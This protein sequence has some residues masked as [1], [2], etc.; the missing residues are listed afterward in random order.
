MSEAGRKYYHLYEDRYKK[1]YAQG[2][3]YWSDFP[4]EVKE[5]IEGLE[6]LFGM[7]EAQTVERAGL[8][9][10]LDEEAGQPR[11]VPAEGRRFRVLEPGCGEGHLAVQCLARGFDYVGIDLAPTAL[12]KARVR[13]EAMAGSLD[14]RETRGAILSGLTTRSQFG[15]A[16]LLCRDVTALSFLEPVS[17]DLAVDNKLLHV[18]VVDGDRRRYLSGLRRALK[19]GALVLFKEICREDAFDGPI[20][21]FEDYMREFAPDLV[22]EEERVAYNDGKEVKVKVTRVPAR[23]RSQSGYVRELSEHGFQVLRFR[24][25]ESDLGCRII[26]RAGDPAACLRG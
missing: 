11:G 1:V 23:P 14:G 3:R 15:R 7:F 25:L 8:S 12:A 21:T 10:P 20:E 24:A 19:P 2:V 13:I 5:E 6:E 26:A 9:H 17:F 18:L 4:W 16:Q 22:T